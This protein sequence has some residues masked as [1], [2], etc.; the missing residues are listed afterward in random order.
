L[1]EWLLYPLLVAACLTIAFIVRPQAVLSSGDLDCGWG[2]AL[3]F[4]RQKGLQ[5]GKDIVFTYGPLGYLLM[6]WFSSTIGG[7][8]FISDVLLYFSC[9]LGVC[10]VAR[11]LTALWRIALVVLLVLLWLSFSQ[12]QPQADL[13]DALGVLCWGLLC[14]IQTGGR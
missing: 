9:A 13:V 11:Q 2:A 3:L 1:W 12:N 4:A 8:R 5:F 14:L 7:I 10:L 6:P